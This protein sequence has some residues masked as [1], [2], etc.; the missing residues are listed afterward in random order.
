MIP[1]Y[2]DSSDPFARKEA[3]RDLIKFAFEVIDNDNLNNTTKVHFRAFLTNF[4][5]NHSADW[6][7]QNYMGRGEKFYTYQGANRQVS[8]NFKV[9]AQSKQEM[10]PLYQ[11]LNYI[12]S[13]LYSDYNIG[14]G[15]MR[16]NI[17]QLTIGE[18][19]Y[20]TPGIITSMNINVEDD[21][22]WEIKVSEPET[23]TSFETK[24]FPDSGGDVSPRFEKSNSDAD[25]MELPQI[26]NVSVTFIPILNELPAL[27]KLNS[28]RNDKRG[29]LISNDV[30]YEENFINRIEKS[31]VE[32][33]AAPVRIPPKTEIGTIPIRIATP[34]S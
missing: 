24:D 16:G 33:T 8:F 12:V 17:H 30:G 13:S 22:P 29:I 23:E 10:M 31:S 15:F 34:H 7:G 20:R 27:S 9:A 1:L 3:A 25:M 5:D 14:D 2:T 28:K 32:L 19:F 18:Y 26:L 11:K 21:Y 4:T 6:N